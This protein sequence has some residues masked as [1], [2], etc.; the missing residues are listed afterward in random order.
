MKIAIIA[1]SLFPIAQPFE[2]GLEK[3]THH[4]CGELMRSG[5]EVHLYAHPASD[6]AFA[7]K[8]F[9]HLKYSAKDD[10]SHVFGS[11]FPDN[12]YLAQSELYGKILKH[13]R[14]QNYDVVHNHSLNDM[15]IIL[16]NQ[17]EVPFVTTFHTP[18]FPTL[19]NGVVTIRP[20]VN[21]TF[22]TVSHKLGEIWSPYI[23]NFRVIHNGIDL[24]RW[25]FKVEENQESAFWY[26]R[27]CKEKAPDHAIEASLRA[28]IKLRLAG[29]ISD[30]DYFAEKV[31]PH[32]SHESIEYLG[33]L[34]QDA[35][36]EEL[37]K[38]AFCF[39]TSTWDEP[40]GLVLAES[41]ACG[42]PILGYRSGAA[43]EIVPEHCGI[44]VEKE[45]IDQ[46]ADGAHQMKNINRNNCRMHAAGFCSHERMVQDYLALYDELRAKNVKTKKMAV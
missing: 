9:R 4:L 40:Y 24:S 1:H 22:T 12:S 37:G 10:A 29:P 46:L 38:S 13:I 20:Q 8:S 26:G 41:L 25:T 18:P 39:F 33:H 44:L 32:L 34:E 43:P 35:I 21:Q 5:H 28:G 15:A 7:V 17:L 36:N 45:N 16:G 11:T 23:D 6:P 42:T 2:G 14:S 27:I 19:Q 31:E 3:I 30:P